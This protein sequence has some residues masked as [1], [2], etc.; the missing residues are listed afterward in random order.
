MTARDPAEAGRASAIHPT[1]I[2]R[3]EEAACPA[4]SGAYGLVIAL[5]R[6]VAPP[7]R[8]AASRGVGALAPGLYVYCG[9]ARGPGGLRARIRRH[10]ATTKRSRWHV[11]SL[12]LVAAEVW[13]L[14]LPGATECALVAALL[15]DSSKRRRGADALSVRIPVPGFGASDCRA[16]P[17]HLL[18]LDRPA[19]AAAARAALT[20]LWWA[21]WD[22]APDA[23]DY[24]A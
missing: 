21:P 23:T 16:C 13:A 11:D 10:L 15:A 20:A 3:G 4:V 1:W 14:P 17:A 8:L 18:A 24:C 12:T 22:A 6:P 9:S 7:V 5:S 2:T 19:E